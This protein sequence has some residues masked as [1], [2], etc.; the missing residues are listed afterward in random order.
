MIT[1]FQIPVK[2]QFNT[3]KRTLKFSSDFQTENK[4]S[5]KT[6]L[7]YWICQMLHKRFVR[8]SNFDSNFYCV[9]NFKDSILVQK[10]SQN[11]QKLIAH[12][13]FQLLRR[14]CRLTYIY[15][16]KKKKEEKSCHCIFFRSDLDSYLLLKENEL[17][18]L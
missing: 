2:Y 12:S 15:F 7:Y 14:Y 1:F 4:L 13:Y 9:F 11:L 8:T 17:I 18:S 6:T 5:V 3:R 10:E 16:Q